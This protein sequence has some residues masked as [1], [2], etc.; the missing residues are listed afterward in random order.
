MS[1]DIA[2]TVGFGIASA[3]FLYASIHL[4]DEITRFLSYVAA[5]NMTIAALG[6]MA[7]GAGSTGI[8]NIV[9]SAINIV[10]GFLVFFLGYFAI[11]MIIEI[12]TS[13]WEGYNG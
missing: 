6:I 5:L 3:V 10:T 2:I 8:L 7:V 12:I 9:F 4:E 11:R 1:A 13:L